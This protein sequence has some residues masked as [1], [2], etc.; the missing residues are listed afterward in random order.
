VVSLVARLAD[1]YSADAIAYRDLW[2]PVLRP[3]SLRLLPALPL[4]GAHRVLDVGTGV[5]CLLADLQDAA[6][7][8]AVVVG[9]DRSPGMLAL[10]DSRFPR[11]VL[12]AKSLPLTDGT[13]DVALAAFVLFHIDDPVQ[14]LGE[15]HRTLRKGGAIG[16]VTWGRD[17]IYPA[18]EICM[19]ELDVHGAAHIEQLPSR[20]DII[21]TPDKAVA[22]LEAAGFT[23][24]RAWAEPSSYRL[25]LE[26]FVACRTSLGLLKRRLETLDAQAR[27]SCI[28]RAVARL[29]GLVLEDFRDRSDIVLAVGVA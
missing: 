14:A 4:G 20:Y 23:S 22:L 17:L 10:A 19:Q 3:L 5:G 9:G 27:A 28:G 2:G 12:D 15:A 8:G 29:E 24:V 26:H 1:R 11:V 6:A 25:E 13:F 21:D 16:A 18:D 7:P